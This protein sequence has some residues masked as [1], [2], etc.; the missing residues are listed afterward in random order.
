[1][2][3]CWIFVIFVRDNYIFCLLYIWKDV[4]CYFIFLGILLD[5]NYLLFKVVLLLMLKFLKL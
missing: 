4:Y 3:G 2:R 5:Y 1:M